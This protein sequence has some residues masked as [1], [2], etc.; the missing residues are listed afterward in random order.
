MTILCNVKDGYGIQVL[1]PEDP[2]MPYGYNV[3]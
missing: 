3:Y 2:F 1:N